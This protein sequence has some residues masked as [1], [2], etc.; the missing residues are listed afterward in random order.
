MVFCIVLLMN[1]FQ[2]HERDISRWL[3]HHT[4]STNI[5]PSIGP[6]GTL[7]QK[8]IEGWLNR[9]APGRGGRI[10]KDG[11]LFDTASST[12]LG[13]QIRDWNRSASHRRYPGGRGHAQVVYQS[14]DGGLFVHRLTMEF[15]DFADILMAAG[16][17]G[18]FGAPLLFLSFSFILSPFLSLISTL[19]ILT[20]VSAGLF[21]TRRITDQ[22]IAAV[23]AF[24][25]R[26]DL[27]MMLSGLNEL[28]EAG[29]ELAREHTTPYPEQ[30]CRLKTI[31][32]RTYLY[33]ARA[34][35]LRRFTNQEELQ[36]WLL[37]NRD[38]QSVRVLTDDVQ[39]F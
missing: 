18:F 35:R 33:D 22:A 23:R 27:L 7:A 28:T 31:N 25:Q 16:F 4:Q 15:P 10:I 5:L 12:P 36:N 13:W 34:H 38:E 8:Q 19:T 11:A 2:G 21:S 24:P 29:R 17:F 39:T 14:P 9:N 26:E 32:D 3:E 37:Q 20:G 6:T 30:D 1:R